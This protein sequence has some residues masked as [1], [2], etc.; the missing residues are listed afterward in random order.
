[1]GRKEKQDLQTRKAHISGCP[2]GRQRKVVKGENLQR[3]NVDLCPYVVIT[4]YLTLQIRSTHHLLLVDFIQS[5]VSQKDKDH[6]N[7][8]THIYGI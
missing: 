1:M 6:Y 7:I 4:T 5:E 8:L 3:L 2:G